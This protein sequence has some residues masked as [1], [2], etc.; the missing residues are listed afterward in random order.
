MYYYTKCM[1]GQNHF[2]LNNFVRNNKIYFVLINIIFNPSLLT[3]YHKIMQNSYKSCF[4]KI[5]WNHSKWLK[6]LQFLFIND[7]GYKSLND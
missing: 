3:L 5:S 7:P 6:S 1:A 4:Y 2:T